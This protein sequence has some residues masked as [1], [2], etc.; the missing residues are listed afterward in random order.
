MEEE[1]SFDYYLELISE[2]DQRE[3]ENADENDLA[4][5]LTDL[6][7]S[8][9]NINTAGAYELSRLFW[10][11]EFQLNNLI[12]YLKKQKP[13]MTIYELAY[14]PGFDSTLVM[15]L[16]PF[17]RI[18]DSHD[19]HYRSKHWLLYRYGQVLEEQEGFISHKYEDG[20][21]KQRL[22]YKY[23]YGD[24]IEAGL[25]L[26]KDGGETMFSGSN[27]RGP[28]YYAGYV[29][30]NNLGK[31][32]TICLG[33]YSVGFGQGLVA[34]PGFVLGKTSQA[35]NIIQK[36]AGIRPY[37]SSDENRYMQGFASTINFEPVE[38]S[39]FLSYKKI[40][41]N[42]TLK[43]SVGKVLEVSSLQN[44]GYHSIKSEI[45]DENTLGEFSAGGRVLFKK[46]KFQAGA[47]FITSKFD[48]TI[49][50]TP[51]NYNQ[52]YF[53]GDDHSNIGIDYKFNFGNTVFFGEE[54]LDSDGNPALLN[55]LTSNIG[56]RIQLS[57]A[58]RYYSRAY[59]ALYGNAFGESSR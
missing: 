14:I 5:E 9:V 33:N 27:K 55:G 25:N 20:P 57:L 3:E 22:R 31:V 8:P 56:N 54:A 38:V 10:L 29:R 11:S 43:D 35:V 2:L 16:K 34:G 7:E 52:Y 19:R 6:W 45:E 42:V 39:L 41:A 44:T 24:K 47:S 49:V 4:L 36:E 12:S 50:P 37:T 1:K 53:C 15:S 26:E 30:M 51:T 21:S 46:P 28:D 13:V 58:H 17:I 18:E 32:K 23:Q 59:Y 40:D 48:A